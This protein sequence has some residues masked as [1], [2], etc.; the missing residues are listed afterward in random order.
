MQET[1]PDH[2]KVSLERSTFFNSL[3]V[4]DVKKK[5]QLLEPGDVV[6][7]ESLHQHRHLSAH[8]VLSAAEVLYVK[9]TDILSTLR[10]IEWPH[11]LTRRLIVQCQ[12]EL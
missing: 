12:T 11:D 6:N 9:I 2:D 3:L 7:L 8:P 1:H 4:E 10:I 5:T